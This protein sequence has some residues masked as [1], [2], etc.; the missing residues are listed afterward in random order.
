MPS[1]ASPAAKRRTPRPVRTTTP[2]KSCPGVYGKRTAAAAPS[3]APRRCPAASFQSTV[4]SAAAR[5]RTSTSPSPGTGTGAVPTHSVR[6][7]VQ[8]P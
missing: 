7:S 6:P 3:R 5:T 4:L 8:H 2:A 1:T